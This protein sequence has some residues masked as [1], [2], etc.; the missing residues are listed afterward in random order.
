MPTSPLTETS[1]IVSYTIL[2]NGTKISDT[3]EIVSI[4]TEQRVNEIA[5]AEIVLL[6]GD[7]T[8]QTFPISDSDTFIPGANIEIKLGYRNRD[9]IAFKGIAVKQSLKIHPT[10][11]PTLRI[12][13]KDEAIKMGVDKKNSV[14]TDRSD[15]AIITSIASEN[16][17]SSEVQATSIEHKES[18]QF[19]V[20]DWSFILNRAA[21]NGMIALTDNG[22]LKVSAPDVLNAPALEVQYGHDILEFDAELDATHQPK[23][24][25]SIVWDAAKQDVIEAVASEPKLNEQG[26]ITTN[27]LS[28]VLSSNVQKQTGLL[29]TAEDLNQWAD[30][31]LLHARMSKCNG[32]I[33]F[34]G[35]TKA[36]AN[37]LIRLIGIGKR[38]DGDAYISGVTHTVENGNW[39]TKVA[40]GFTPEKSIDK[41]TANKSL[42]SNLISGVS[43]LQTGIVKQTFNDPDEQFRVQVEIPILGEKKNFVWA[44]LATFYAGASGGAYFMPEIGDE[45]VLGFMNN[46]PRFPVILGSVY[47]SKNVAPQVPDGNNSL[48][49][50]RTKN[51][52]ELQFNDDAKSI[53]LKT[54]GGTSL[55]ISD[56]DNAICITDQY[57]NEIKMNTNGV[58]L[59]SAS[60]ININAKNKVNI[61]GVSV[62]IESISQLDVSGAVVSIEGTSSMNISGGATCSIVSNGALNASAAMVNIN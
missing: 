26:N 31:T 2:S 13:C 19:Y 42:V 3:Y 50:I 57:E 10:K 17:L 21:A 55:I 16:G 15:S 61:K 33:T 20:S 24:V 40:L 32:A 18:V 11:G 38:F 51:N 22:T 25:K 58:W 6:D 53:T 45:V 46:D 28:S 39:H 52:L 23:E 36:K 49:T 62:E 27:S 54:P 35:S 41:N 34:Q 43:G 5:F 12:M 9:E 14:F 48:K 60:D 4:K 44:R 37:S 59:E 1:D 56:E 8:N 29:D 30:A 47:S 7:A